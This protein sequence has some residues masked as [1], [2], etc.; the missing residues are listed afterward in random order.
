[1][2]KK[3]DIYIDPD[4]NIVPAK[5]VSAYDKKR[6]RTA[7]R[8]ARLWLDERQR[9]AALKEKTFAMIDEVRAQAAKDSKVKLGGS[10][11]YMQFRDFRGHVVVRFENRAQ[12]EFDER[13]TLVQQLITQAIED[14]AGNAGKNARILELRKVADAA[15]RPRGKDG[16]LDRQ[17][18][19][20]IANVQ[21]D[22]SKWRKAAEIIRECDKVVGH[23]PYIRVLM[24][25][26]PAVEKH[27]PI[28]LDI[29]AI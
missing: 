13:L 18:V 4:D 14:L 29:S 19:R 1:M 15:F 5:H 11:G 21:V 20:D 6:D 16:K 12:M 17:R 28:T 22:H 26:D 8:I 7:L 3:Q 9:L 25:A 23:K 2:S 24:T 10:K 27:Q